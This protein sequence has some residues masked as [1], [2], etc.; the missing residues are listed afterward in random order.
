MSFK[1]TTKGFIRRLSDGAWIPPDP[2][3]LDYQKY[4]KF[5]ADGGTPEPADPDPVPVQ[6]TVEE[7]LELLGIKISD[8][9]VAINKP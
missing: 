8:L 4:L 1:L 6:L 9:K 2:D 5:V 3:N 7:K